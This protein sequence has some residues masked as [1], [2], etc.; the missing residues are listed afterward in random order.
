MVGDPTASGSE[1][2]KL[3]ADVLRDHE[4]DP[5]HSEQVAFMPEGRAEINHHRDTRLLSTPGVKASSS[6]RWRPNVTLLAEDWVGFHGEP[7]WS[8]HPMSVVRQFYKTGAE[9]VEMAR[10]LTP[11]QLMAAYLGDAARALWGLGSRGELVVR[12]HWGDVHD[13]RGGP[14]DR[15]FISNICDYTTLLPT[16]VHLLPLLRPDAPA[17]PKALLLHV[18]QPCYCRAP[19]F[20]RL[21]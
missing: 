10:R 21:L 20:L 1:L 9:D 11:F 2:R 4:A 3:L 8:F 19:V 6:S 17:R 13:V 7:T 15:I 14:F 16:F 5:A 12:L 18:C